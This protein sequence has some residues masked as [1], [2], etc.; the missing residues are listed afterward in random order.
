MVKVQKV[1]NISILKVSTFIWR[2]RINWTDVWPRYKQRYWITDE[3]K[4]RNYAWV[5]FTIC[6]VTPWVNWVSTSRYLAIKHQ[7]IISPWNE[8]KKWTLGNKE[9]SPLTHLTN[10]SRYERPTRFNILTSLCCVSIVTP[11]T[12]QALYLNKIFLFYGLEFN[13]HWDISSAD[14]I[15]NSK[16]GWTSFPG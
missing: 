15:V 11:D 5:S 12:W 16:Y 7:Q 9:H 8:I 13:S 3:R 1:Q 6:M 4:A 14:K 2:V 10:P